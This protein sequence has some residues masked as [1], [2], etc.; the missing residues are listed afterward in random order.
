VRLIFCAD[1]F[2]QRE[3][4]S[5]YVE[6]AEAATEQG[7]TYDLISFEA[8]VNESNPEKAVRRVSSSE[9]H[10]KAIYRGW[11]LTPEQ[12]RQLHQALSSKNVD[13]IN[14]PVEYKHCHY[15]PESFHVIREHSPRSVWIPIDEVLDWNRIAEALQG[16]GD[17]PLIVKDYVKSRKH[18]W[19]EACFVSSASNEDEALRVINTFVERQGEDLQG[20]VVLREFVDLE[21]IGT[22][23][24]S[25]M[26]LT[27]EYRIFFLNKEPLYWTYYWEEGDYKGEMPSIQQFVEIAERI[28][29]NFFTM[30]VAKRSDGEWIIVE[31]GDGQVAGLPE[32]ANARIF[33]KELRDR[34]DHQG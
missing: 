2:N 9:E 20:G 18:E 34:L 27:Q 6:E 17:S 8:L 10:T 22:H 19:L 14:G 29:S 21:A 3:P 16:F 31:L 26:P 4:D 15:L 30:D 23:S 11:M 13:L 25:G 24:Q 32:R 7:F 28:E 5:A 1:P 12:Y 33:Y